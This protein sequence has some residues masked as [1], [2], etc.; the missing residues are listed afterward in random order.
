MNLPNDSPFMVTI[1]VCVWSR[2]LQVSPGQREWWSHCVIAE[3][4]SW[5]MKT[6]ENKHDCKI[7]SDEVSLSCGNLLEKKDTFC[8]GSHSDGSLL[9]HNIKPFVH[10]NSPQEVNFGVAPHTGGLSLL[11]SHAYTNVQI[12]K[13]TFNYSNFLYTFWIKEQVSSGRQ[14]IHTITGS[15]HAKSLWFV[16]SL[17]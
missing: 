7:H 8:R 13:M 17:F 3:S 6:L 5:Q 10:R 16:L 1:F 15:V 2:A 11:V 9:M 12:I 14:N 4:C